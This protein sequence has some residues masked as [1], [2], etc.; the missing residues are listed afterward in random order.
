MKA[1][2]QAQVQYASQVSCG[3]DFT[4]WL[5]KGQLYS[6]GNPQYGQLGHGTDHEH[7]T[8]DGMHFP[9]E[10]A[11]LPPKIDSRDLW[12]GPSCQVGNKN[13]SGP[14]IDFRWVVD[15]NSRIAMHGKV[16]GAKGQADYPVR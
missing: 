7:N 6:A 13:T 2:V 8:K 10:T 16:F 5:C 12:F 15:G 11:K 9:A 14:S 1:P 3:V 4:V